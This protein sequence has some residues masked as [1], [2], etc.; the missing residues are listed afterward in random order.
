MGDHN[1]SG[2][3]S[4]QSRRAFMRNLLDDLRALEDMIDAGQIESGVR[5][6]GAEQELFLADAAGRPATTALDILKTVDDPHFTTELGLFNLEIN[7]DPLAFAG[8][9]LSRLENNLSSLLAK[10]KEAAAKHQ[11]QIVLTGILPTLRKSDLTLEN[12]TPDPRYRALNDALS[13]LRG[14]AYE[15]HI[16]GLDEIYVQHD[17]VMFEACNASFQIHYQCDAEEFANIYNVSQ[18]AT[19]PILAAAVNSP[20]LFGRQLWS[21]TRIALFQQSV[22][23]RGAVAFMRERSPRVTFGKGWVNNSIVELFQ[24]DIS[25]FRTVVTTDIGEPSTALL[26]RGEI[27]KLRALCMHNSTVYRWNRPCYGLTNGKP[28]LRIENRVLPSGPTPADEVANA[29]FWY[30]L[31]NALSHRYCD[32]RQAISFEDAKMN[33]RTAARSG[34]NANYAWLNGQSLPATTLIC[35]HLLPLAHEGLA[36]K[37]IDGEDAEKYLNI[38]DERV[39]GKK[40]GANW[41]V[42]SF[43]GM[44]GKAGDADKLAAL[45]R[46]TIDKQR[47]G[48]PVAKWKT[49][50]FKAPETAKMQNGWKHQFVKVEQIMTTD[51]FTVSEVESIDLVLNMM[52]WSNIRH[53]PVEDEQHHL[54]GLVSYRSIFEMMARGKLGGDIAY[55]AGEV[56]KRDLITI[57]MET[58]ILEAIELMRRHR[59]GCLP[60]VQNGQLVGIVSERDVLNL[61]AELLEEQ[62]IQ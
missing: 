60:V 13:A 14:N 29:A 15:L 31:V 40:T 45:T 30:G 38:I 16:Y 58:T 55:S 25:R 62:L 50:E 32:I 37:N 36:R 56:M 11:T 43:S 8:D 44:R 61:A 20:L 46:A 12:M 7:L 35:D 33:F 42:S 19:A 59:V 34:L 47:S 49:A 51:L 3:A 5:R 39:R 48:E 53:V 24:E 41:L 28:H 54:T 6:I 21:E 52:A 4:G 1:V 57:E 10:A 2:D 23:T 26:A 9:C 27:P 18:V 22:D 17:S